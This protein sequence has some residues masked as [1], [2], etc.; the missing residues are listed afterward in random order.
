MLPPLVKECLHKLDLYMVIFLHCDHYPVMT[1]LHFTG[2][3]IVTGTEMLSIIHIAARWQKQ[4]I[5]S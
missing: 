4:A 5:I 1:E 2:F 3:W